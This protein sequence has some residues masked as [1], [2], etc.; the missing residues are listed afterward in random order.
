M[1]GKTSF[2]VAALPKAVGPYQHAVAYGGV[3]YTS[4][5][6]PID[7]ATNA[8][9]DGDIAAQTRKAMENLRALLEGCGSSLDKLLICRLYVTDM[10]QFAAVNEEYGRFF[11]GI[12]PPARVCVEVSALARGA[13]IEIE[14]AAIL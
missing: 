9:I 8:L 11:A 12:E 5:Q 7:A 6:L 13:A 4:A 2:S 1:E 3:L 14:A 10:G